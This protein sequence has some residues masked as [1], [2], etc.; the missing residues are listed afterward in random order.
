MM[1]KGLYHLL[2][3]ASMV[4]VGLSRLLIATFEGVRRF[5]SKANWVVQKRPFLPSYL[6]LVSL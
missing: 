3:I 1:S 4:K 2:I 6:M 5:V